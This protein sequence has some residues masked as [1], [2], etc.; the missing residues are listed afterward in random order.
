VMAVVGL[1]QAVLSFVGSIVP[2]ASVASGREGTHWL[3]CEMRS[4]L[5]WRHQLS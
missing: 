3:W 2:E 4:L 5:G 1:V